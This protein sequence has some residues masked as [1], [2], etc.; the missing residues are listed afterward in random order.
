M[1]RGQGMQRKPI[2]VSFILLI[3][4][5][6][7]A[8]A[9]LEIPEFATLTDDVSNDFTFRVSSYE[10]APRTTETR[11]AEAQPQKT[12]KTEHREYLIL[13]PISIPAPSL[14]KDLLHLLSIQRE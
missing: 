13:L 9:S 6:L 2:G 3:G 10:I 8:M 7:G 1:E 11:K 5:L 4:L 14:T 12:R